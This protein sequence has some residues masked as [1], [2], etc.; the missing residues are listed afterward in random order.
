VVV[1]V[2]TLIA[3]VMNVGFLAI[4]FNRFF[5]HVFLFNSS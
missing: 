1:V 4:Y 3:V 5:S 2:V